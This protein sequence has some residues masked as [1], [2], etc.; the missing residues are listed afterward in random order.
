MSQDFKGWTS[1]GYLPHYDC[2][3][4][5]QFITFRLFD[6][7][8]KSLIDSWKHYIKINKNGSKN[9]GDLRKLMIQLSKYEDSGYGSCL[10]ANPHCRQIVE[11]QFELGHDKDYRLIE[12]KVMPNHVHVLM[13]IFDSSN[14]STIVKRWKSYSA[15]QINKLLKRQGK[16]WM[17]GYYDTYI[18]NDEHY[19]CVV[20]YIRN[21]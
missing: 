14:L 17:N 15:H 12:Y 19:N 2:K 9:K 13:L 10:L 21:N 7:L 16:V 18:R 20:N 1:R 5:N 6:S 8:P 11:H 4:T 3:Y